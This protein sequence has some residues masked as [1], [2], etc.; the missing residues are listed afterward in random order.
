METTQALSSLKAHVL[1]RVGFNL[2]LEDLKRKLGIQ[3]S[4]FQN[5]SNKVNGLKSTSTSTFNTGLGTTFRG[6]T[7]AYGLELNSG[8]DISNMEGEVELLKTKFQEL[9]KATTAAE[10]IGEGKVVYASLG[11]YDMKDALAF[12]TANT[13]W[14]ISGYLRVVL[15]DFYTNNRARWL[16]QEHGDHQEIVSPFARGSHGFSGV[17]CCG[18]RTIFQTWLL[19]CL[20]KDV[21]LLSFGKP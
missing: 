19:P 1:P 6:S 15:Q 5:L 7:G 12:V 13:F 11:F 20:Q 3:D 2:F 10:S 8:E 17:W 4:S 18:P 16:P 9:E 21:S 14:S